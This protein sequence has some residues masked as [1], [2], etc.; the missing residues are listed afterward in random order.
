MPAASCLGGAGWEP[1]L[2]LEVGPPHPRLLCYNLQV[3]GLM[4]H[5]ARMPKRDQKK[6]HIRQVQAPWRLT[7]AELVWAGTY[8]DEGIF[9]ND[10]TRLLEVQI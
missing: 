9:G 7:R 1:A 8:D 3:P 6:A 5:G 4:E 10:T 2:R